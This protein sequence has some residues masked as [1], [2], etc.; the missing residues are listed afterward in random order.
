MSS[1]YTL[2]LSFHELYLSFHII[3]QKKPGCNHLLYL[4]PTAAGYTMPV[5]AVKYISWIS[6]AWLC[7]APS[8]PCFPPRNYICYLIWS[9]KN[10]QMQPPTLP[11][12]DRPRMY[13]VCF[14]CWTFRISLEWWWRRQCP[15]FPLSWR[16]SSFHTFN[17]VISQLLFILSY[18][19]TKS[20]ECNHLNPLFCTLCWGFNLIFWS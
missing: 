3:S 6:L 2:I 16:M 8:V 4:K 9:Y 5:P 14:C 13:Y 12:I 10:H 1:F 15:A 20:T 11:E 17:F 19:L 7:M 18:N